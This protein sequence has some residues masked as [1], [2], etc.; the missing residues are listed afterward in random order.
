MPT[1]RFALCESRKQRKPS[2]VVT[3]ILS[4]FQTRTITRKWLVEILINGHEYDSSVYPKSKLKEQA[5]KARSKRV[6][7]MF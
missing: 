2:L 3:H 5:A 1:L 4:F 7:L 6:L